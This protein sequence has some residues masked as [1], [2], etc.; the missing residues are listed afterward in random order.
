MLT[1]RPDNRRP[2]DWRR[3]LIDVLMMKGRVSECPW[4]SKALGGRVDYDLGHLLPVSVYPINEL[5]NLAP[6]DR[7]FNQR[8]KRD[9]LPSHDLLLKAAPRLE[10]ASRC[11]PP[12]RGGAVYASRRRE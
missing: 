10:P 2:L 11:A 8:V 6:A 1:D 5:W 4:T 3:N 7:L 9:R 12:G